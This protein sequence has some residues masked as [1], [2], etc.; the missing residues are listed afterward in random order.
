[1]TPA[2]IDFENI[3]VQSE[4]ISGIIGLEAE[5]STCFRELDRFVSSDQGVATMVLRAVNSPFYSR[6]RKVANIPHAIATLGF[7]VVRSLA[8]LAFSRAIFAHSRHPL[9]RTHIWH[10]SLLTAIAGRRIC[11]DLGDARGQDDAFVAGLMHDAGKVLLFIHDQ[12]T[13]LR[14]LQLMLDSG[15]S[16]QQAEAE[17][18][19][20]DHYEVGLEAV[21]SWKLP[22]RFSD[23]M[24]RDLSAPRNEYAADTVCFSLAV[25]NALTRGAGIG[26]REEPEMLARKAGLSAFGAGDALCDS[27]LRPEFMAELI[28]DEAYRLCAHI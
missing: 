12:A 3:P 4:V 23:Y 14:V 1:M 7:N 16:S 22:E 25:A 5:S 18:M 19:G 2:A 8:I 28:Q 11:G 27:W 20:I 10:H 9:F 17:V 24:A 26:A 15:C 21:V 6:G 13:Y